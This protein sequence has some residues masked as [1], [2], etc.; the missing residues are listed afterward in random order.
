PAAVAEED[1]EATARRTRG[2]AKRPAAQPRREEPRRRGKMTVVDALSAEDQIE[3]VRS[4]AAVKRARERERKRLLGE[5]PQ[6]PA[7]IV[8]E[9]VVPETITV[10]DLAN[11][12]AERGAD[13]IKT[14]MN[15]GVM[16]TINHTI[17]ADAAELVVT[18]MGH[19]V[20][21]VTEADVELGIGGEADADEALVARPPVVTIMG[22]VDHGK[23]SLLD[24]LRKTDVAA[25]EAGGITQHIGAYQV[26]LPSGRKITFIDT[27]GHEAFTAMRARGA[28]STDIVVL[29]VAAD[30]GVQPQ[31]IEAINHAKAAKVPLIVAVNKVDKPGVDPGRVRNELLQHEIVTEGFGG[32]VLSV[33]VSAVKG[34][35]LDK[36]EEAILLQAE[37]LELKSN[38]NRPANGVVIESKLERGRGPVATVLVQRGTLRT[39]DIFIAGGEWGR[40]RG[41]QN[42]RGEQVNEAGPSAPVEVIGLSGTPDAGDEFAVVENEQRAREISEFRQGRQRRARTGLARGTVEQMFSTMAET[43]K[44][45]LAVVIKADVQ[46]SVEAIAGA[47]G[48]L[49]TDEVSAVVLHA[50]VGGITESDVTLAKA[51]QGLII[52]FNVRAVPQAR[53]LAK[54]DGIEI[55]YYSIIYDVIDDVKAALSGMLAPTMRERLIGNAQVRQVFEVSKAGKIAGCRVVEGL[56]RRNAKFRLLRDSVVIY[57]GPLKSLKHFKEDVREIK[58]GQECGMAFENFQ[59]LREGDIIEC[60]EV[61]QVQRAL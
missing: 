17:D 57:E 39:G 41:L 6:A 22:H 5:G 30:D 29:V 14:L 54:R 16:A 42:E 20:K 24:A 59:D 40:V 49:E 4:L 33:D 26:T 13:V 50:G 53:E 7:K 35:N 56:V 10:Q 28:K 32:D 1:E 31:T 11:R 15:M 21:R 3:R 60:Y 55:R 52:G 27:P 47:L 45:K 48:K 61:E 46:G 12:M 8:R 44:K 38:P 2:A 58:E 34:T 25:H 36:L 43:G 23:T 37:I 18:E 9:V 19:R 51:S